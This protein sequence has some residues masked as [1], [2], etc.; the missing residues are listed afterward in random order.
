MVFVAWLGRKFFQ[1]PRKDEGAVQQN[2]SPVMTQNFQPI[3][4]IHPLVADTIKDRPSRGAG[5]EGLDREK[6]GIELDTSS[7][8][9]KLRTESEFENVQDLWKLIMLLAEAFSDIP[10]AGGKIGPSDEDGRRSASAE[11]VKRY[12][13]TARFLNEEIVIPSAIAEEARGL[14]RIAFNEVLQAIHFPDPF[15]GRLPGKAC[16][17]FLDRRSSN[18]TSFDDG[19]GK[20]KGTIRVFLEGKASGGNDG[21]D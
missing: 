17:D 3:I 7:Q 2:A 18:L 13:E 9:D 16:T 6:G 15:D 14:L 11:F 10:K 4:N 12:D 5:T 8:L 21:E 20:L 19:V 1:N